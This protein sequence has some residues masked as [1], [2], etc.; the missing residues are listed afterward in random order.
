MISSP[1]ITTR[2]LATL[3]FGVVCPPAGAQDHETEDLSSAY[4]GT[5]V[6]SLATGYER[7]LF[8]APVTASIISREEIVDSGARSLAELLERVPGYYLTTND[9]RSTQIT[10][11]GLTQ[12]VLI[13][14]NN[15][16]LYQGFLN[17]T[18]SLHDVMLF[19]VERVEI[20]RGP[21]SAIYGAD[22]S[23]GIVNVITR[24]ASTG[25]LAEVG[26]MGGNVGSLGAY[27]LYGTPV[28]DLDL[29]LYGGYY[30][31]DF[32]DRTLQADA[33]TNFDRL[34]QTDA[35]LAPGPINASRRMIEARAS[36]GSEFWALRASHRDDF[37]FETGTGLTFALDPTGTYDSRV[38]TLELVHQSQPSPQWQLRGYLA[39]IEVDQRARVYPYP[40]GAFR[41]LFPDGVR[42]NFDVGETRYRGELSGTYGGF[43]GHTLL[44]TLGGFTAEYDTFSD[45][46]NY[47]VRGG[48]VIPTQMFA[49]GAGVNDAEIIADAT[50][51]VW[52]AVI[53]DEWTPVSDWTITLGARFDDYSDFGTTF[54]PRAAVVWTPSQHTSVKLLYG[55]AFRPPS[56]IELQSNGTFAALGNPELD[57]VRLAMTELSLTHRG[58]TY[59][60]GIGVFQ[61][62]QRDLVQTV[63]S[64]I[65]PMGVMFVN[66]DS[67]HGWG[68]EGTLEFRAN[69]RV[70]LEAHYT[71]QTHT[72]S[73]ADNA[74]AQQAPR[75]QISLA[76]KGSPAP[77]WR[78]NAFVLGILDRRRQS[79]DPRPDPPD[80]ALVNLMLERA[81]LPG[82]IDV[83][84]SVH[85]LF[86]REINDPSDSATVLAA[87]IPVP[88]RTWFAQLRKSF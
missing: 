33:Q 61:Y 59:S 20:T 38:S 6:I 46:R 49:E 83:S 35:S 28:H 39:G 76:L 57:P 77:N 58:P 67:D 4:G 8:D 43:S 74:N 86:D 44:M 66:R 25:P 41:G 71:Y 14:V 42:Q 75:H 2:M 18:Q 21:G 26:V 52:Y 63:P 60:T 48:L 87:D 16:P 5:E 54:N 40:A 55:T 10:V 37:D 15:L 12:R 27:G 70:A 45:F 1:R 73:T 56:V 84:L 9:A 32:T 31:T 19:D 50:R 81:N 85:N 88:G 36:L 64:P 24:T 7:T 11:R 47:I 68:A 53:Q 69:E 79:L 23:A 17:A 13:L 22:A 34:L 82:G 30:E 3:G 62:K 80:Y 72:G 65:S 51:D 29:R 78:A